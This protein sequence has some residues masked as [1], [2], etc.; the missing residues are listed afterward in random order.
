M[1]ELLKSKTVWTGVSAIVAAAAG[2]F[3]GNMDMS[4]ALQTAFTGLI[5]I[6]LRQGV[7][8]VGR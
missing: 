4:A 5:G 7:A 2:Y 3:T 6:F 8:K 1:N